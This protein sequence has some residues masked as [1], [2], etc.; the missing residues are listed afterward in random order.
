MRRYT[1]MHVF[2][3]QLQYLT[4]ID[5]WPCVYLHKSTHRDNKEKRE[6]EISAYPPLSKKKAFTT[7]LFI[8]VLF[9]P[10]FLYSLPRPHSS[11]LPSSPSL[12]SL[13]LS[14]SLSLLLNSPPFL[15]LSF[16]LLRQTYTHTFSKRK[17]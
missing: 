6:R 2:I 7:R 16:R 3:F 15:V 17:G 11:F 12:C 8:V 14:L 10:L 4:S 13:S 9:C 1:Y 5:S